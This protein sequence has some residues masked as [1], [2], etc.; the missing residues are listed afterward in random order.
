MSWRALEVKFIIVIIEFILFL[1]RVKKKMGVECVLAHFHSFRRQNNASMIEVA[2]PVYGIC[3][4]LIGELL[5]SCLVSGGKHDNYNYYYEY[6]YE[7]KQ[8]RVVM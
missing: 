3:S 2:D 4:V 1:T 7:R 6:S 5:Y 8:E